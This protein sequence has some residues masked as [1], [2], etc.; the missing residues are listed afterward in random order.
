MGWLMRTAQACRPTPPRLTRLGRRYFC[1]GCPQG[2]AKM[3]FMRKVGR[4]F[5]D[6]KRR[7]EQMT[8]HRG[9][10]A[11][12]LLDRSLAR[13]PLTDTVSVKPLGEAVGRRA[14][15]PAADDSRQVGT[16]VP[17]LK[18]WRRSD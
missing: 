2:R 13:D 8:A 6:W 12:T 7:R 5:R 9:R 15:L 17:S 11:V 3:V 10:F 18:V 14:Y 4:D 16:R 1:W